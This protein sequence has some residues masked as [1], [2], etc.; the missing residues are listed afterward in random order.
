M[1]CP[2]VYRMKHT[3]TLLSPRSKPAPLPAFMPGVHLV[4][5]LDMCLLQYRAFAG[6]KIVYRVSAPC[7][8]ARLFYI[9]RDKC[10]Y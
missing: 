1:D 5:I 4:Y 7:Y 6:I 3:N 2:D 9:P 10:V 8:S